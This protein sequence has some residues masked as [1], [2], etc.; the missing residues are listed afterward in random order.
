M[1]ERNS[2]LI[3]TAT[4]SFDSILSGAQAKRISHD[5]HSQKCEHYDRNAAKPIS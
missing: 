2:G 4:D 3:F 1:A 5:P